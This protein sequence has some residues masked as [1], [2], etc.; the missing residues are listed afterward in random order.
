[1]ASANTALLAETAGQLMAAGKG[2]LAMDEST[3]TCNRRFAAAGIPQTEDARRAYREMLL[4]TPG[5]GQY[6][7][8]VILFDETIGQQ[9]TEGVPFVQVLGEAGIVVGSRWT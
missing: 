2:L 5:L 7:S 9:T 1:M 8:G 6:I 4:C 3:G